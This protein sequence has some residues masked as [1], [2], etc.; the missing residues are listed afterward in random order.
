MDFSCNDHVHIS[1]HS[2]EEISSTEKNLPYISKKE[3]GDLL[4]LNS[5]VEID[6]KVIHCSHLASLFALNGMDCYRNNK[7]MRIAEMFSD[8]SSLK[9]TALNRIGEI[10]KEEITK[11]SCGRHIVA[12]NRFGHFLYKMASTMTPGEQRFFILQSSNHE[13]SFN[14]KR[15]SKEL[16][17][18]LVSMWVIHFFDPNRTNVV[19]RSEVL[20][21]EEFLDSDKFSLIMFI[22]E[23]AYA[24][25][26]ETVK[27][28]TTKGECKIP[29]EN[30]CAIYEHSD[31]RSASFSFSTLETM[32]KDGISEC[33]IHHMMYSNIGPFD[34]TKVVE[35]SSFSTLSA[36]SRKSIFTSKNSLGISA[37]YIAMEQNNPSSV[38]AYNNFLGELSADE[39]VSLLPDIVKSESADG[40][41]A[42][43][44]AMQGGY[45]ECISN[46]GLLINRLMDIRHTMHIDNFSKILFDVLL[47]KRKDDNLSALSISV[48]MNKSADAIL[49]FGDLLDNIFILKDI[50]DPRKMSNIIFKLL[51]HKDENGFSALVYALK[52]NHADAVRALGILV[53]RLL[54]MRGCI[55]DDDMVSMLFRLLESESEGM[56]AIFVV[57]L[58]GSSD[59]MLAFYELMDRLFL[60]KGHIPDVDMADLIFKLLIYKPKMYSSGL[61]IALEKGHIDT[62]VAFAGLIGKVVVF[63]R[64]SVHKTR[65]DSM[66]LELLMI[67][68]RDGTSGIFILLELAESNI[69][70]MNAYDSLLMH[71]SEEVRREI[72]CEISC[73]K[74]KIKM[75]TMYSSYSMKRIPC[76]RKKSPYISKKNVEN[77]LNLNNK[78][79]VGGRII[80]C[81]YL[82]LSFLLSSID[83][84]RSSNKMKIWELFSDEKSVRA[85]ALKK[86][87]EVR[88]III[89]RDLFHVITIGCDRFGDFLHSIASG[90]IPGEQRFFI[91]KCHIHVMSFNVIHKTKKT[92]GAPVSRWVVHFFDPDKTNVVSRSEVLSCEEFLYLSKF[93][94]KMFIGKDSYK[95]YFEDEGEN[96]CRIYEYCDTTRERSIRCQIL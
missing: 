34:I 5:K 37:L 45:I 94:L 44:M 75:S 70:I 82:S 50:M 39:Q 79:E 23:D 88:K 15:K 69:D 78:F 32:S 21:P 93:S 19:T 28:A 62:V 80:S 6:G 74:N 85:A 77:I 53:D 55:P 72:S 73:I 40:V 95:N 3:V 14:I 91:L 89:E 58:R 11:K 1:P 84:Y 22:A 41:P 71:A 25:Y 65:L 47:A 76:D 29:K 31:V 48:L 9:T 87:K 56:S 43:F 49:A 36:N 13:M 18:A 59:A 64:D 26:F 60:M 16:E 86:I 57:L 17:G 67:R 68:E 7:K 52:E 38:I 33:M 83:C 10:Y 2:M 8:E 51:D 35:S 4:N 30:E 66:M 54:T 63:L 12:C 96:E 81:S 27:L 46:F 92:E 61:L 20:S 42:L 90:L 24:A